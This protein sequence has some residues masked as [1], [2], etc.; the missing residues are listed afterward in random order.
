MST[1]LENISKRI[2]ELLNAASA[3]THDFSELK[4]SQPKHEKWEPKGGEFSL[5]QFGRIWDLGHDSEAACAGVEFATKEAAESARASRIFFQ[6]LQCLAAELNPSGKVGG[7]YEVYF[8]ADPNNWAVSVWFG[9]C[10]V[11][12]MFETHEAAKKAAEVLTRDGVKPPQ[13]EGEK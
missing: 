11:G 4:K 7:S 3:L 5:N 6:R 12:C 9:A 1:E 8:N 10:A 13:M 2:D